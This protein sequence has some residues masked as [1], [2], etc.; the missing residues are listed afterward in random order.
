MKAHTPSPYLRLKYFFSAYFHQNW[1]TTHEWNG[2]EPS[3]QVVVQDFRHK[4]SKATVDQV[5]QDLQHILNQNLSE[6]MLKP[7]VNK[8]LRSSIYAPGLGMT[9]QQWLRAVLEIL[10]AP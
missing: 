9:Y 1:K 10:Q 8:Q 3:F 5:V 7:L 4:N 2:R 6:E